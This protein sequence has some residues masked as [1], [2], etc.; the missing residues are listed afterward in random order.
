MNAQCVVHIISIYCVAID[1]ILGSVHQLG[2]I[3][4]SLEHAIS[5]PIVGHERSNMTWLA[6]EAFWIDSDTG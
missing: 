5:A 2:R 6:R 4:A 3:T 1:A